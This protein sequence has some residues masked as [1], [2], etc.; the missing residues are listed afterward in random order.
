MLP[1]KTPHA[2]SEEGATMIRRILLAAICIAIGLT[3]TASAATPLELWQDPDGTVY[4]HNTTGAP[5]SF[6]GYQIAS[7]RDLLDPVGW[8]SIADYVAGGQFSEVI[9]ALGAGGLT[10]GEANPGAGNLAELNLGGVGT[11]Q[12]G[13][14]FAI[15]KPLL[16]GSSICDIHFFYKLGGQTN[17]I[18]GDPPCIPEPSTFLLA[19]L[20]GLGLRAVRWRK[21]GGAAR[22]LW[23]S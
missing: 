14:K 18:Q 12:A 11:L 2:A 13:A 23:A 10:F 3:K 6:D 7:E 17:S 19:A 9:A 20:A 8:K 21:A 5:I 15:G 22:S 16:A 4:L 1:G